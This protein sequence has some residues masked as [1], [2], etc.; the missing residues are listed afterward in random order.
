MPNTLPKIHRNVP[1]KSSRHFVSFFPAACRRDFAK[2]TTPAVDAAKE[3]CADADPEDI[4]ALR[5]DWNRWWAASQ[6]LPLPE[7]QASM[8][9]LGAAWSAPKR[10]R[11]S[12]RSA[13]HWQTLLR[14][15]NI[16]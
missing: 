15:S 3:F 11:K 8:R 4:E 14:A 6:R 9:R 5:T 7:I 2:S 10:R 1:L 12:T 16:C 13:T